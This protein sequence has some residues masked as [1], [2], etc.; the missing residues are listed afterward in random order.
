MQISE[1]DLIIVGGGTAG[2]VLANRLSEDPGMSVLV[3]EAGENRSDD[4]R[5]YTPGLAGSTLDNPEFDWQYVAEPAP[6]LNNRRIKHPRGRAI[7]GSSAI[8]SL[9]IIYPS[10]SDID[11]WA[12]I[13]NDDWDWNTLAPYF[14]KF[15][16]IVPPNE[17]VKKQLNI[18]HSDESICKSSGP[19]Q[20]SFPSKVT[21][22]HKTWIN[23]FH[24]LSL[25]NTSDPLTG[26]AIGGHT[27]TCHI[28]GDR[29]ERSH[30]GVAYLDPV[31]D[32]P[33][34][35]VFTNALVHK[36]IIEDGSSGPIVRGVSYSQHG[37]LH[38]VSAK[39][40]VILAAG[41]FNTPQIL[42]LSG[43]GNPRILEEHGI[44]LVYA[45][46][47]V[48]EN[49]QDHMRSG[50]S[51]EVTNDV[52]ARRV[53]TEKDR[54]EYTENRSGLLA[55]NGAF[56]FS[57]TPLAPFLDGVGR[58]DLKGLLDKHLVDDGSWSPFDRK[59]N[60]FIRKAIESA[61]EA[62]AVTFLSR[63]PY[64][65]TEEGNFVSLNSMLSHPFSVGSVHI[66]SADPHTKPKI[67]FNYH[68]HPLDVEIHA[69]HMQALD[70]LAKTEPF[71]SYLV[72]G[73]R[74]L[75][76]AYS[77]DTIEDYKEVVRDYARTNYHPCGTCSLGAVADSHLNV[78][79]VRNLRVVDA[80]IMPIIP[81][82]N[83]LATVYAVAERAADIITGNLGLQRST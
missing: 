67:D 68:S 75:P 54:Q 60:N 28:T 49:L 10:A 23:T 44:D 51:F 24:T 1:Y 53:T 74:R 80:S 16:T 55:E 47:A 37:V 46:S 25:E 36:L 26:H 19:V 6:G 73:G 30:A 11:V 43:I 78:R 52:P 15:Q 59:R 45:N 13:G 33:N 40:E 12:E 32:R 34:L 20:A 72:P 64:V 48:G 81:R 69:R 65:D 35:T 27:S 29:H 62:S 8:N 5:V 71:A 61:N 42:E 50:L 9:A 31:L 57:Y 79:G 4:E 18:I 3:L 41:T 63:A 7:G 70:K 82:G 14:L 2:C 21:A 22:L 83:I 39:R 56:M 58:E 66:T 17:E 76:K 38:R 77:E